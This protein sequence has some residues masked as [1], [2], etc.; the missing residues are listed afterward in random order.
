MTL[1]SRIYQFPNKIDGNSYVGKTTEL[2]GFVLLNI[3]SYFVN[4][5]N[6][7]KGFYRKHLEGDL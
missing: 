3:S 2:D 7:H 1:N 6:S 5:T 4:K